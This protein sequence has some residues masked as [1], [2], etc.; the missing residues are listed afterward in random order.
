M[1]YHPVEAPAM[2]RSLH[3]KDI[4]PA[5]RFDLELGERLNVL[6]GDN[7]LGKSFVLEVAWWALTGT[8]ARRPVQPRRGKEDGASIRVSPD[9]Y[10]RSRVCSYRRTKQDWVF[11]DDENSTFSLHNLGFSFPSWIEGRPPVLFVMAD[12]TLAVWDP[13]RNHRF[14]GRGDSSYISAPQAYY[15]DQATLWNGL[16]GKDTPITNGLI[17]DWT[18]WWLEAAAGKRSPFDLLAKVLKDLSH[19]DEEMRPAEPRRIYLD[20]PRDYPTVDLPYDNVPI[21]HL[22]AGMRRVLSLAYLI[23]W[24]WT[25]HERACE[26]LGWK[27]AD[28]IVFLMDEVESHLHPKWQR[29]ITPALLH[30]LEG[31]GAGIKPQ[32]LLTTHAPLVMASIEPEFD[33]ER[34]KQ[35]LFELAEGEAS[36]RELPWAKQGDVASWLSASF[37][38]DQSRSIPGE[39]V[40]EAAHA[41][42]EGNVAALPEGLC[43]ED[44]IERELQ[45]VLAEHDPFLVDWYAWRK[46]GIR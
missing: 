9:A 12:G 39:R 38:L 4:G 8:W 1:W 6:T 25:E 13:A 7:G 19:P 31:L 29:H 40:V 21:A 26:L 5:D 36:L 30:V 46:H 35:F 41:L 16:P 34:D 37:G 43:T 18:R 14:E 10:D 23:V 32:L 11:H 27:P 3:M 20:D 2:L 33:P 22:S 17:Q 44:E 45:R 42:I 15:F 28:Q 24:A